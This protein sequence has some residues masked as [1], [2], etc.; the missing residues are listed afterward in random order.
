MIAQFYIR[1]TNSLICLKMCKENG[2]IFTCSEGHV[3]KREI[4]TYQMIK[5]KEILC[6]L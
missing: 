6:K 3:K 2:K 1:I 5:I 4:L